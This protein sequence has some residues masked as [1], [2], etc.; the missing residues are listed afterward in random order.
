MVDILD[1]YIKIGTKLFHF[2]WEKKGKSKIVHRKNEEKGEFEC[3]RSESLVFQSGYL[4]CI[5]THKWVEFKISKA[6]TLLAW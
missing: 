4:N 6:I 5:L 3:L 2:T 1:A